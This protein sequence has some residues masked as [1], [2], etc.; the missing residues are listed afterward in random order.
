MPRVVSTITTHYQTAAEMAASYAAIRANFFRLPPKPKPVVVE[1]EPP[2]VEVAAEPEAPPPQVFPNRPPGFSLHFNVISDVCR[3]YGITR[4]ELA[5]PNRRAITVQ[6]R[7]VAMVVCRRF[8]TGST[9]DIGRWLQN[10][11]HSSVLHGLNRMAPITAEVAE[12]MPEEATVAQWVRVLRAYTEGELKL[13]AEE[14]KTICD[15]SRTLQTVPI[16]NTEGMD[17]VRGDCGMGH[18][19][20]AEL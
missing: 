12:G 11:D 13:N 14:A 5:A 3:E 8:T 10:M 18:T 16:G 9:P 19:P 7:F 15:G 17:S 20:C 6:R 2:P 4:D 1:P